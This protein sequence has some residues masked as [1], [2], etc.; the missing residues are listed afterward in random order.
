MFLRQ[1][2][3]S[4]NI[5]DDDLKIWVQRFDSDGDNALSFSDFNT[6]LETM[7]NYNRQK[8]I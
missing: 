2:D 4:A 5:T 8:V 7:C 1:F 3:L 6:A